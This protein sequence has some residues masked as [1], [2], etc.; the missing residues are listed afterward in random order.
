[1]E[2]QLKEKEIKGQRL[3][4]KQA[5][6]GKEVFLL[7]GWGA[8]SSA[9]E[10]VA[11][12][13]AQFF[14]VYNFDFPGFGWSPPPQS[15]WSVHDYA[16]L[17]EDFARLEGIE[18]PIIL[19]HSFGGRISILLGARGLPAKIV[20]VDSA[21]ILPKRSMDYYMKVYSYKAA[22]K[23]FSLPG[24]RNKKEEALSHWRK[25]SGSSDYQQAEGVMK[26][27]F[28]KVVNEDLALFLP[29]IKAP[30]L[31]VWGELDTATPLA[32]GQQMEKAITGS[33]LAVL[34]GAGHYSYLERLPQFLR[35]MDSFLAED[36]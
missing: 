32:D 5:G 13:L 7:H 12:H 18:K 11:K 20:L 2:F 4:Y 17:I 6:R 34:E 23:F 28:V 22:K 21:G 26:Q 14:T 33:G 29:Q 15:V 25:K 16:S 36:K 27:I 1:M 19:G 10:P 30:T 3:F 31:L 8:D 9:L 24:L 35:I